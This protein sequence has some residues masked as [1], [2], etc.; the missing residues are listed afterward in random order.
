MGI[1]EWA[2]LDT[3]DCVPGI[4]KELLNPNSQGSGINKIAVANDGNTIWAIVRRGDRNGTALG[5]AQVMLYRSTDGGRSWNDSQY[6]NLARVQSSTEDGVFIWDMTIAPDDPDVIALACADIS[7]SPLAQEVWISSDK[8]ESWENTH[9]PPAGVTQG[10]Q[11]IGS[12]DVCP[13]FGGRKILIGTRDGTGLGTNNLQVMSLRS[14]RQ[15]NI[16]DSTGIQPSVNPFT[17]DVLVAKFSPNFARDSTVV[18]LYTDGDNRHAGTWLATGVHDID[19]NNTSWQPNG[20][21]VEVRNPDS[22][23]GDSPRVNEIVTADVELPSDFCGHNANFRRSYI[24]TD[25][26]DRLSLIHI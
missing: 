8:G 12:M 6:A 24:S 5:G 10:V 13:E 26:V 20:Q 1:H 16:Q 7:V 15:W 18:V 21:H 4:T 17:G 14:V 9:W 22:R 2:M 11:L 25:A 3:P 19:K 23:M